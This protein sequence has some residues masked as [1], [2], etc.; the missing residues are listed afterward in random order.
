MRCIFC[1]LLP[2]ACAYGLRERGA[3]GERGCVGLGSRS[4]VVCP[5]FRATASGVCLAAASFVFR[6]RLRPPMATLD[7]PKDGLPSPPVSSSSS[8]ASAIP[9]VAPLSDLF[10]RFSSWR[11]AL[12]LPSPGTVENLTKE[13]KSMLDMLSARFAFLYS[14]SRRRHA[15]HQLLLR[16]CSC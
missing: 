5:N 3:S 11:K 6:H 2:R 16:R 12:E 13:V 14:H 8:L 15:P 7:I 10:H 1:G 4:G 9:G